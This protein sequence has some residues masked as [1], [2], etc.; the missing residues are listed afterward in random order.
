MRFNLKV[1]DE[2]KR[3]QVRSTAKQNEEVD[4]ALERE[5]IIF[6]FRALLLIDNV[7]FNV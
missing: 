1:T 4:A 5:A 2:A 3:K 7:E 6:S